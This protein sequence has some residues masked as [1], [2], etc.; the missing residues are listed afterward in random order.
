MS[1]RGWAITR[2]APKLRKIE[3]AKAM[4]DETARDLHRY[5]TQDDI[6]GAMTAKSQAERTIDEIARQCR[7]LPSENQYCKEF[8]NAAM[9]MREVA[10]DFRKCKCPKG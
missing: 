4:L 1:K 9:R 5:Y 3:D 10:Q 2:K 7:K 8:N 6:V